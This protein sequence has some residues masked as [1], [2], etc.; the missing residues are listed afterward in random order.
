MLADM[1]VYAQTDPFIAALLNAVGRE[2]E[3]IDEYLADFRERSFP[4]KASG[5]FLA[6]WERFLDL[7]V[8]PE[9]VT[10]SNRHN[11]IRAAV[12]KRTAGAGTGWYE[13]LSSLIA[14][15]TF[16][17]A[18]NS[19]LDGDYAP[20]E[21]SIT[22][23]DIQN[24]ATTAVDGTQTSLSPTSATLTV[25]STT[26][27]ALSG[28]IFVGGLPVTFS[29]KTSTTFQV[30]AGLPT[31]VAD[32]TTVLQKADY[33]AGLFFDAARKVN[34]AHIELAEVE[35]AG[36]DTFRVGINEVGDEI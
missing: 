6:Y 27:F 18:E 15:A 17:H 33:R 32:G 25:D 12:A 35:L 13:L 21:L 10:D 9:G 8:N 2:L 3:R 4:L 28:T 30:V 1:P 5:E 29:G 7:P 20:Y 24:R 26:N 23:I 16:R 14:P 31:T 11:F 34:P 22:G 19:N 36:A